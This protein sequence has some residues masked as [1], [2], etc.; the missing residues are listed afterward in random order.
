[1]ARIVTNT[2]ANTVYKNYSRNQ[3]ALGSSMEKLAT[4]LRINRASDDAAGLAISETLRSQV[5]GTDAAVDVIANATN[6]INT[7]DG[8]LQTVNDVLG[9]ME[10][11]AVSYN[12]AT[13]STQDQA[14][15][16]AEFDALNT[17]LTVNIDAQ[18]K[19]N[20]DTIFNAA[21]R[22]FQVGANATD[23]FT[24]TAASMAAV[25][26]SVGALA[27]T[28]IGSIQ[29]ANTAISTQRASL[30]A[31]QSQLNYKSNALQNYSENVSAAESRIRN[32]DVAKESTNFAKYQILVQ[33]STAMLAQANANSQNVLTLLK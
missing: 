31:A 19:F 17:E 11:L 22:T 15:I 20:G 28:D 24:I 1:M 27:V 4:G 33:A 3:A 5:K 14:N 12:D 9:R 32:V 21:D 25:S 6:F 13:K 8:Y 18:A 29:A 10:E 16:K 23:T 26:A 2:S 30:G 7:A